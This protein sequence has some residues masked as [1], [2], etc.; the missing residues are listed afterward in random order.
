SCYL[1]ARLANRLRSDN[2]DR[3]TQFHELAGGKV[4]S[5]THRANS[6]PA[7][8]G[9]DRPNF[10]FLH[11]RPL[12]TGRDLLV[13]QLVRFYQLLLLVDR[14]DNRLAT[15]TSDDALAEID[16]FFV[17]LVNRP[18]FAPFHPSPFT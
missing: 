1:G 8:A 3:F 7:F 5:V 15:D 18:N 4:P 17:P 14:V 11:A 2:P 6:A 13:D 9:Q 10:Q 12:Q 16:P